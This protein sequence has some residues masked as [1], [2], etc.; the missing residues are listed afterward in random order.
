V[1]KARLNCWICLQLACVAILASPTRARA[2]S[3]DEMTTVASRTSDDYVRAKLADGSLKPE[4]YAFGEGGQL[5]GVTDATI[6]RLGF[7]DVARTVAGPLA[8]QNYLPT[9]DASATKLLILVYWGRTS[10]PQRSDDSLAS[11]QLQDTSAAA[12]NAKHANEQHA[13]VSTSNISPGSAMVCGHV[14]PTTAVTNVADQIESDNA[15]TGAMAMAAAENR[16]RDQADI[17]NAQL[18]GFDSEWNATSSYIGTPREFRR[19]DLVNELEASRY[20]VVLMA[21]DF[22]MMWKQK[23][24]KLL[25]ETRVSICQQHHEFDK[26]LLAMAQHASPFFGRDSHG[27]VRREVPQGRVDIGDIKLVDSSPTR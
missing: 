23:K 20:F 18:L 19:Q 24:H 5:T 10:T 15:F 7:I 3:T 11:Q 12:S 9:R 6:K 26:E 8:S 14:D 21:Y 4:F 16:A 17:L 13:E 27:L 2:V 25:W 22:Q 1:N